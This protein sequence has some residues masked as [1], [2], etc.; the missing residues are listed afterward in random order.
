M[1]STS[2]ELGPV[3]VSDLPPAPV[4]PRPLQALRALLVA[5]RQ[6]R[7][8]ERAIREVGHAQHSELLAISRRD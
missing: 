2:V 1:S 3:L 5:R 7:A 4:R 8:F 6:E